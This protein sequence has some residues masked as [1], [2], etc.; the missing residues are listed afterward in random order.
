MHALLARALLR[1]CDGARSTG[2]AVWEA[3]VMGDR[4]LG[5]TESGAARCPTFRC[6]PPPHAGP[7]STEAAP[8]WAESSVISRKIPDVSIQPCVSWGALHAC[9]MPAPNTVF[10]WSCPTGADCGQVPGAPLRWPQ[11]GQ[12]SIVCLSAPPRIYRMGPTSALS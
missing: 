5:R 3:D 4:G 2:S 6:M 1:E 8:R 9:S 11:A 7:S 10:V 12:F